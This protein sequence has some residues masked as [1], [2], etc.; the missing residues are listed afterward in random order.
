MN[1]KQNE[2]YIIEADELCFAYEEGGPNSLNGMNLKITRGE[3]VAFM[4]AN[5]SG[6]ST[7]FLCCN[8]IHKPNAGKLSFNGVPV[9]YSKNELLKLRSK[10]GI[11]FQD[12]DNQL[13]SAS[14]F[15]EISFG[16]LNLCVPAD[17]ARQAVEQVIADLEITPFRERPAHALSG[18]EKKQVSIADIVVMNPEVII[19]DEPAASL[20][21]KHTRM[22]NQIINE[23]AGKGITILIATHDINYALDWADRIVLMQDGKVLAQGDPV[24]ICS[25]KELLTSTNLEEPAVLKMFYS[26]C[27]KG[28]L[29]KTLKPPLN[30]KEL[31]RY[32]EEN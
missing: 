32:I 8:G 26:L 21:P 9:S 4:G 18:G 15:Q 22:V 16:I 31:E 10:V 23:L 6:K 17:Q 11:V 12:P 28:I 3:K 5:G 7:F 2:D 14:V 25:D 13:F 29:P 20:D 27:H 24:T 1:A 30:M 19:L